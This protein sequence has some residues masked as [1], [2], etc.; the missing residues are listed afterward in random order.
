MLLEFLSVGLLGILI[1]GIFLPYWLKTKDLKK[2]S[3]KD[4]PSDGHWAQLSKGNIYY[5][6]HHPEQK[7]G[8]TIVMV[9][10]FS[11]PSFVWNGLLD[12]LLNKGY[13]ILVY[14]HYGRGFSERPRT[15]YSLD[16]YVETLKELI[17]HQNIEGKIHLVGYSMGG[18]IIGGFADKYSQP[19]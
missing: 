17:S 19:K 8:Q 5:R 3:S 6:W 11:T 10:G 12:G 13:S 4:L 18:P 16:F 14:D 9:H 2:I 15:K 1:L 7:N